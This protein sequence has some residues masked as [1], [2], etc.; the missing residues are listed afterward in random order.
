[1]SFQVGTKLRVYWSV[2]DKWSPVASIDDFSSDIGKWGVL[3]DDGDYEWLDLAKERTELVATPSKVPS[4]SG[5]ENLKP[6]I[7]AIP[8]RGIAASPFEAFQ[9][10]STGEKR[11]LAA[12]KVSSSSSSS[13][14]GKRQKSSAEKVSPRT[15]KS[16]EQSKSKD[17]PPCRSFLCNGWPPRG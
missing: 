13:N 16:S 3:Y 8:M 11:K 15:S 7:E 9:S 17:H 6:E 2:E 10:A 12:A 4:L 5:G 1:M 14:G